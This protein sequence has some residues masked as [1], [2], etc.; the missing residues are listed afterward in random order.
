MRHKNGFI[1]AQ[2]AAIA[3]RLSPD[4]KARLWSASEQAAGDTVL[5]AAPPHH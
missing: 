4:E 5:D 2:A 1:R 3:S